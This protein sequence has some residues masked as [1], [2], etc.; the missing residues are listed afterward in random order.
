MPTLG[1]QHLEARCS[2]FPW[3]DLP[4]QCRRGGLRPPTSQPNPAEKGSGQSSELTETCLRGIFSTSKRKQNKEGELQ[5]N[6]VLFLQ[7]EVGIFTPRSQIRLSDF[8]Q[9]A[10]PGQLGS[11]AAPKWMQKR[12][13]ERPSRAAVAELCCST[14]PALLPHTQ[15]YLCHSPRND[16]SSSTAF[17]TQ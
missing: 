17:C 4:A 3:Q 9:H 15:T 1:P 8:S 10:E 16:P 14:R 13:Q 7:K 11:A 6:C 12:C 5:V 2:R